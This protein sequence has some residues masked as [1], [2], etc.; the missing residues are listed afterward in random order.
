MR[1]TAIVLVLIGVCATPAAAQ[2]A[3]RWYLGATAGATNVITDKVVGGGVNSAGVLAGLRITS[4]LAIEVEASR[5]LGN[6]SHEMV[7]WRI[8]YAGPNS[9]R[10]EIERMAVTERIRSESR[11]TFN[12]SVMLVWQDKNRPRITAGLFVGATWNTYDHHRTSEILRLPPGITV[13]QVARNM[14][15]DERYSRTLGGLTGGFYVPIALTRQLRVAPEISYTHGDMGD[16]HYH[17]VS[18][19]ARVLWKF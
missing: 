18:A 1:K 16:L 12:R 3:S 2:P 4:G 13:E 8:S 19:R 7:G 9:S 15:L 17:L 6:R 5:G 14:P 10:E 11:Q